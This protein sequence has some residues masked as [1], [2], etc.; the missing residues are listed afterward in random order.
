MCHGEEGAGLVKRG[1]EGV[2]VKAGGC[3]NAGVG[4][5][6]DGEKGRGGK[7]MEE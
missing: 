3:E 4:E 5:E 1:G 6:D 7:S 2:I